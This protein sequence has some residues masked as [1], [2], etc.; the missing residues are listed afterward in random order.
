M[1]TDFDQKKEENVFTS[2]SA[3]Q[4]LAD[5]NH[6]KINM[7]LFFKLRSRIIQSTT[8]SM[9][10]SKCAIRKKNQSKFQNKIRSLASGLGT[11]TLENRCRCHRVTKYK[12]SKTF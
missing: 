6:L 7:R 12:I 8:H 3:C 5:R 4:I 10:I 1:S 11:G 9:H 2:V